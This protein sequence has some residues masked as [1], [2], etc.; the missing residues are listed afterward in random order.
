MW[1]VDTG[2]QIHALAGYQRTTWRVFFY[3]NGLPIA[4]G[5]QNINMHGFDKN[6]RLWDLRTGHLKKT[7]TGHAAWIENIGFSRDGNTLIS[8]SRDDTA[9][10]WDLTPTINALDVEE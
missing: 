9:L 8:L 7:L 5:Y 4:T 6:I 1:D 10:L 3:P 2:E